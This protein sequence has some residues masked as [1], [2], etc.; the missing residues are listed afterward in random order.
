MSYNASVFDTTT[1]TP[2]L[3]LHCSFLKRGAINNSTDEY[4]AVCEHPVRAG[5]E[6]IGPFLEDL[7]TACGLWESLPDTELIPLP[8][9]DRWQGRRRREGFDYQRT[10][11]W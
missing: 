5:K 3:A 6:C 10:S 1:P 2:G 11:R 4:I 9:P 7:T 8:Q